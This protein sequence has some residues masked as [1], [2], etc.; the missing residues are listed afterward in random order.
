MRLRNVKNANERI[1]NSKYYLNNH[2]D[3]RGKYHEFFKNNNPIHLEIGMGK[4]DFIIANALKYPDINFIGLEKFD[5]VIVRALEKAEELNIS[6]LIMI[7]ADARFI[8]DIFDHEIDTIYLNFSD[9]WP[10]ERHHIR[11][12]TS[13]NFLKRYESVFEKDKKII[14]KTDNRKLFEYSLKQ[15]VLNGYL[16]DDIS[17]DLHNDDIKDNIETEYEHKFSMKG[18]PIYKVSVIK[19]VK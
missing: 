14:Q 17:L 5:S 19:S 3:Y 15:Y 1:I 12:L 11:R 6:N 9:P 13:E 8:E 10:K 2:F 18:N 7:R 16:I 4:G